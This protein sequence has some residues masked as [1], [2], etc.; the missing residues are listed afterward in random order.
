[1]WVFTPPCD[2]GTRARAGRA[3][4]VAARQSCMQRQ[5]LLRRTPP[6]IPAAAAAHVGHTPHP[7]CGELVDWV[8]EASGYM[9]PALRVVDAAPCGGGRGLVTAE[10]LDEEAVTGM[11][12]LLVPEDLVLSSEVARCARDCEPQHARGVVGPACMR[13]CG[14]Q[15]ARGVASPNMRAGL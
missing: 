6:S 15:H 14:L 13:D 12:M 7:A 8:L 5:L 2:A 4:D 11:P 9:H 3:P 10:A 1:M